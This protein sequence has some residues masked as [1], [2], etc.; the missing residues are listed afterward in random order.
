MTNIQTSGEDWIWKG[1]VPSLHGLRAVSIIVV[2]LSHAFRQAGISDLWLPM[3][4]SSGVDIFFVISGFLITLLLIRERQTTGQ[5]SLRNFYVRRILRI[6]PAYYFFLAIMLGLT[7]MGVLRIPLCHFGFA[8][9]YIANLMPPSLFPNWDLAHTWSLC[10]EE[11]FYLMWPLIMA[12]CRPQTAFLTALS[13][14]AAAPLIRYTIANTTDLVFWAL[15]PMRADAMACG[16]CLAFLVTSEKWRARITM[17]RWF[18][19]VVLTVCVVE[20][21]NS[22]RIWA[23]PIPRFHLERYVWFFSGTVD[24]IFITVMIWAC[25]SQA[26][27]WVGKILNSR[28]AVFIGAL[29]YSLYLWQQPIFNPERHHLSILFQMP[30]NFVMT[31]LI[32][33]FSYYFVEQRILAYKSR[34]AGSF[35]AVP[36]VDNT[37]VN[38]DDK[39]TPNRV[40]HESATL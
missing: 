11:H 39:V 24:A 15:T 5:I 13:Y 36:H 7:L 28:I 9:I 34:L 17:S 33:M 40:S 23:F 27:G 8:A 22:N 35:A 25:I 20:L 14:V 32:A 37:T 38:D 3:S 12:R 19:N 31:I 29:S 21:I 2:M 10:V 30:L 26:E 1:N 6:C 16:C 4:G 18:N